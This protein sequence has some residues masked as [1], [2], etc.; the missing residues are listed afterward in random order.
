MFHTLTGEMWPASIKRTADVTTTS[1]SARQKQAREEEAKSLTVVAPV[2]PVQKIIGDNPTA[3]SKR[4]ACRLAR[5]ENTSRL[6]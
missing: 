1:G 5:A 2:A 3:Q 6:R 4:N